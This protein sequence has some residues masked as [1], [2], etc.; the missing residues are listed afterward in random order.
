MVSDKNNLN[1]E[2]IRNYYREMSLLEN[3]IRTDKGQYLY[4]KKTISFFKVTET[5]KKIIKTE[6][7]ICQL[8]KKNI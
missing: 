4:Q 2:N 7:E 6:T 8:I 1:N 5:A 3:T